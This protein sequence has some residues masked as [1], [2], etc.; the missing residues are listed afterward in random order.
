M[1]FTRK[2][3][4]SKK[5]YGIGTKWVELCSTTLR[6]IFLQTWTFISNENHGNLLDALCKLTPKAFIMNKWIKKTPQKLLQEAR[7]MKGHVPAHNHFMLSVTIHLVAPDKDR[8]LPWDHVCW[9]QQHIQVFCYYLFGEMVNPVSWSLRQVFQGLVRPD[10]EAWNWRQVP[11]N[12]WCPGLVTCH[13]EAHQ[14][15]QLIPLRVTS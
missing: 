12:Q 1:R 9:V 6:S 3:Y 10:M 5:R 7:T 4:N 2:K 8:E 13:Q 14:Q 11:I 15:M